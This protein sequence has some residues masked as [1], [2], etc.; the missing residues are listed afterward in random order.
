M[1]PNQMAK[2]K[3]S[4]PPIFPNITGIAHGITKSGLQL[5]IILASYDLVKLKLLVRILTGAICF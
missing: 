4:Y 3:Q 5:I 2:L 1:L